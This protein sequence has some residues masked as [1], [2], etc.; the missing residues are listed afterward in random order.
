MEI[1]TIEKPPIKLPIILGIVG[2]FSNSYSSSIFFSNAFEKLDGIKSIIRYDYRKSLK[3]NIN[4][5]TDIVK[6]ARTVDLMIVMKGSGM[7]L[8]SFKMCAQYCP[9]LY[10]MMDTYSHFTKSPMML[11]NSLFCDYRTATGYGTC[12]QWE[13]TIS[14]PVYHVMDGSAPTIYYPSEKHNKIY[15]VSFI[16]GSDRERDSVYSLLKDKFKVSFFGPKYSAGFIKPEEFRKICCNSKIVLNISRGNYEGYSSLRL[17]N[18]LACGSMVLTKKIP[19]MTERMGLI[20]GVNIVEFNNIIELQKKVGYYLENEE[21]RTKIEKA[22][23]DF[24]INN[25]TWGHSAKDIINLV[26]TTP[27]RALS[28]TTINL[29]LPRRRH[30]NDSPGKKVKLRIPKNKHPKEKPPLP[31]K[32]KPRTGVSRKVKAGWITA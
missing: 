5:V 28:T 1:K 18:L 25:R 10:W 4:F 27:G 22:G 30:K 16:G 14:L 24:L 6:I 7:P 19:N 2:V 8:Q 17:W 13:K 31:K 3:E 23:L 21:E 20:D 29:V 26:T 9:M 32:Q 12:T 11:E 15:D